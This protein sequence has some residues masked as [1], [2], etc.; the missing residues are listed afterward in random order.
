LLCFIYYIKVNLHTCIACC[1]EMQVHITSL[2]STTCS[3]VFPV[4]VPCCDAKQTAIFAGHHY[5]QASTNNV[6]KTWAL[7]HTTGG[8]DDTNIVCMG[9]YKNI[10]RR[11]TWSYQRNGGELRW[12]WTV[13]MSS[14][15]SDTHRCSFFIFIIGLLKCVHR[16]CANEILPSK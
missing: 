1:M 11:A 8:K 6:N 13:S 2:V 12:S 3:C 15:I 9:L 14:L 7:L 10:K 16:A 4:C 5:A